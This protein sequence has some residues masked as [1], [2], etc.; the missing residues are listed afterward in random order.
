MVV[1]ERNKEIVGWF[2]DGMG[3]EEIVAKLAARKVRS[4]RRVIDE[5]LLQ[6]SEVVGAE[7]YGCDFFVGALR[8]LYQKNLAAEDY[9]SAYHVLQEMMILTGVKTAALKA[10]HRRDL[11]QLKEN[12]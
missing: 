3:R 9:K 1:S 11:A 2:L 4:P 7:A 8:Q 5:A 12:E 10:A 6:L